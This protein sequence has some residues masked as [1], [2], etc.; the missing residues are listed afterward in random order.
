MYHFPWV[1]QGSAVDTSAVTSYPEHV[2]DV[3][4]PV[5]SAA[6]GIIETE[7][8]KRNNYGRTLLP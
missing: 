3:A 1:I 4:I 6:G 7:T 2:D 8:G 5:A